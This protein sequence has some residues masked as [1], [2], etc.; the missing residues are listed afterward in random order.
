MKL[1]RIQCDLNFLGSSVAKFDQERK[2]SRYTI[3]NRINI[4][5]IIIVIIEYHGKVSVL[6]FF[7]CSGFVSTLTLSLCSIGSPC[8][9]G[10]YSKLFSSSLLAFV[11]HDV[12]IKRKNKIH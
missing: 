6:C 7:F 9:I 5:N 3:H 2:D 10:S 4:I 1:K 12:C 8:S 11:I